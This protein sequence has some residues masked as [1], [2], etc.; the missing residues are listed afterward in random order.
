M[1]SDVMLAIFHHDMYNKA[2]ICRICRPEASREMTRCLHAKAKSII[3]STKIFNP[4]TLN[5][6]TTCISHK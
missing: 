4:K 3:S 6:V 5:N 2:N 1:G